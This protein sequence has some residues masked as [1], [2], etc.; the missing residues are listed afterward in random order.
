MQIAK[1]QILAISYADERAFTAN[2]RC[3][4]NV[5]LML[6]HYLQRR[7]NIKP[8]LFQHLVF[9]GIYLRRGVVDL[10]V[11]M[12]IKAFISAASILSIRT[13]DTC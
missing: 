12:R 13:C 8:K 5:G 1:V 4:P 7:P 6:L 9:A 11:A 3:S 10:P 2:T